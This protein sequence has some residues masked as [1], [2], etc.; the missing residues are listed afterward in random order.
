MTGDRPLYSLPG[1]VHAV[2]AVLGHLSARLP[3]GFARGWGKVKPPTALILSEKP[4]GV[5]GG[6]GVGLG[7]RRVRSGRQQLVMGTGVD[8]GGDTC[9]RFDK[10]VRSGN[11][12]ALKVPPW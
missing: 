7:R 9:T 11:I 6:Q 12:K 8:A 1:P 2:T 5:D 3:A 10:V 4:S